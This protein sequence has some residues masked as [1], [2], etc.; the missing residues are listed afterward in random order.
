MV[1]WNL[2]LPGVLSFFLMAVAAT[3]AD[4]WVEL[5]DGKSLAGWTKAAHGKADY[6]VQDGAILG[7]TVEK[8]PNTFLTSDREYGDFELEFEVRVHDELNSGVQIR[9]REKTADDIPKGSDGKGE[10][11]IGRFH[12]PQV[13]IE[14]SPGFAGYIYG[15]STKYGWLSPEPKDPAVRHS[16]MKN[17]EWNQV[18]VVAKGPRIQTWVNGHPVADLTHAASY[19]PPPKGKIGLQVHGIAP[20]TGPF[21]VAWRNIRIRE[22]GQ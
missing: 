10:S 11:G 18:R 21:D 3:A 2:C 15:E 9:S 5:F 8:S 6:T 13:E 16:R 12:G 4:G 19:P 17:G 1:R 14:R 7:R 22:T 20:G